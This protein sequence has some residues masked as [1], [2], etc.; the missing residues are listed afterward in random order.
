MSHDDSTLDFDP[1]FDPEFLIDPVLETATPLPPSSAAR[2]P[3]ESS[4]RRRFE[5]DWV[6][7]HRTAGEMV[8]KAGPRFA[9][10]SRRLTDPRARTLAGLAPLVL[11]ASA[12]LGNSRPSTVLGLAYTLEADNAD[13]EVVDDTGTV[14]STST[15]YRFLDFLLT[16][17][18]VGVKEP[19]AWFRSF[20]DDAGVKAL[21][22]ALRAAVGGR[23]VGSAPNGDSE[24]SSLNFEV[25]A[26]ESA[27]RPLPEVLAE[28]DRL[29]G[30]A[31]VKEVLREFT[32]LEQTNALRREVGLRA[33]TQ[34]RHML[35]LGNPGTGKTT[36]ARLVADILQA[37]GTLPDARLVEADR[38]MLIGEWLGSSAMK[39]RKVADAA[40]GGVL[41]LDEAYSL[42]SGDG[43][44]SGDR[45]AQEAL[46]TLVKVMEDD[47]D[48]LVVILAG[49]PEPMQRLLQMNPGLASRIGLT[50][51]F[52]DYTH[53]ELLAIFHTMAADAEYEVGEDALVPIERAVRAAGRGDRFGN[54][55][56][57]RSLLEASIRAHAVRLLDV[58]RDTPAP[59][60]RELMTLRFTDTATATRR[61][62]SPPGGATGAGV[63]P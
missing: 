56:F 9:R 49:Y 18:D 14:A 16:R 52:P 17:S 32:A 20:S 13:R 28:L 19:E 21:W 61:T 30:L 31:P 38:S 2:E 60:V 33:G 55:R 1:L 29:T 59:I 10:A 7:A 37:C 63:R 3:L 35:F 26:S 53:D 45:F 54:A 23:P 62:W 4:R 58:P 41:F 50:V 47:R 51:D 43:P 34:S 11:Y 22:P 57:V 36:V 44:G 24:H 27:M 39:T 5:H 12:T 6:L 15:L 48:D 40:L 25:P 8:D 46:D 42:A